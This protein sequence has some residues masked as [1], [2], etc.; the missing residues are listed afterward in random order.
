MHRF[1][2]CVWFFLGGGH[3]GIE[4][5]HHAQQVLPDFIC[6]PF[7]P[8]S[9]SPPEGQMVSLG[10]H[11]ERCRQRDKACRL[12]QMPRASSGALLYACKAAARAT[13]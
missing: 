6:S 2:V 5:D 9:P 12:L 1:F 4:S 7:P 10:C 3:G 11:G 8:P 13:A